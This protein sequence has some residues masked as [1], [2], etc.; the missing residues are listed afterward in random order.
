MWST[1]S[2]CKY[3]QLY[4]TGFLYH[5]ETICCQNNVTK[6]FIPSKG[7]CPTHCQVKC[8]FVVL[9]YWYVQNVSTFPN[10]FAIVFLLICMIWMELTRTDAVF[11]RI[12]LVYY[13]CAEIKVLGK[14]WKNY[15]N[16]IFAEDA[17]SQKG[18]CRGQ[19]QPPDATWPRP[20]VGRAWVP[21][22]QVVARL[23]TPLS[24]IYALRPKNARTPDC[25]SRRDTERRR[26]LET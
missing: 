16:Y 9:G 24:P 14:I 6:T 3:H 10:T 26:H 18:G 2:I 17:R 1:I 22:G 7:H 15:R 19:P 23:A 12:A 11:S 20:R 25:F 4:F 13:F 8:L 21:P 5:R